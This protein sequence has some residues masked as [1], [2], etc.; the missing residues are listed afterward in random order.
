[1]PYIG[2][3]GI[4][5]QTPGPLYPA[6][7]F[8]VGGRG[9]PAIVGDNAMSLPAC[10][11]IQ[12]PPG[13][14]FVYAGLYSVI[15]FFDPVSSIWRTMPTVDRNMVV[16]SDGQNFRIANI[17]GGVVGAVITNAGSGLTNGIGTAATGLA[18]TPSAGG[19]VWIPVVG[20]AINAT[21]TVA[22][23]GSGYTLP[24]LV[25]VSMPPTGGVQATMTATI[26]AGAV[27]AITVTNQGAGY[28]TNP[29]VVVIPH[30]NE[31]NPGAIV[32]PT[33]T[34][35]ALT[36]SG[37]LTALLVEQVGTAQT[38]VITLTFSPAS[39]IAATVIGCYT[40]TGITVAAGGV[41]YGNAQPFIIVSGAGL[42]AGTSVLTQP[43]LTSALL[44]PRP[45]Q[46][47]GVSTAGGAITAT[48]LQVVDGGLFQAVPVLGVVP[49]GTG[50]PTTVG[51]ATATIGGATDTIVVQPMT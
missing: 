26:A 17:T 13:R 25:C 3:P 49:A 47:N 22:V 51:Q 32:P 27:N 21:V 45:V 5:L 11:F 8:P 39:T 6:Q 46:I 37:T 30:P 19:S 33:L 20:G 34:L 7:I 42:T 48:G 40:V 16:D 9:I 28:T 50:T 12:I 41:A 43:Q 29:T 38:A 31:P 36:G 18:V 2:G 14:Q 44:V 23:G 10:S 15:Q 35:G 1:M 24:P 4:R